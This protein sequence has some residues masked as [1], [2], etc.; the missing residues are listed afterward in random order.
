M[1]LR[2]SAV[3]DRSG[4][5]ILLCI[6]LAE[7][8]ELAYASVSKT[9]PLTGLWVRLPPSVYFSSKRPTCFVAHFTPACDVPSGTPRRALI[10]ASHLD[11]FDEKYERGVELSAVAT[12]TSD[13][14]RGTSRSILRR[15]WPTRSRTCQPPADFELA[16]GQ[17]RRRAP[18]P[19]FGTFPVR[20]TP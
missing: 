2:R 6:P 19:T 9:D 8:A 16:A 15:E 12:S 3:R 7:V 13:V 11:L 18:T 14:P 4:P 17:V 10:R 1:A 5:P 20:I